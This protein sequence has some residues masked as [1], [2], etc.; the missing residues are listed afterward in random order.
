MSGFNRVTG[1]ILS[2]TYYL[3]LLGY[4]AGITPDIATIAGAV[5]GLPLIVKGVLKGFYVSVFMYHNWNGLR[6]IMWDFGRGLELPMV[7]RTGWAALAATGVSVV[8][9]LFFV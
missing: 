5:A 7:Y 3:Y 1:L 8:Y 2:G 6:H 4:A 9:F